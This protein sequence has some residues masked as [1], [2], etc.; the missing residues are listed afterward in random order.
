[1]QLPVSVLIQSVLTEIWFNN[2][3]ETISWLLAI[4]PILLNDNEIARWI[5]S[6]IARWIISEIGRF[7]REIKLNRNS[8]SNQPHATIP[9]PNGVLSLPI[10]YGNNVNITVHT[11]TNAHGTS[12]T[13]N[14]TSKPPPPY[15]LPRTAKAIPP[16]LPPNAPPATP[17]HPDSPPL[18][19]QK[20]TPGAVPHAPRTPA[21][22]GN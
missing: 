14:Y 21:G 17:S 10:P 6:E 7:T 2:S 5:I 19:R 16:Q 18:P 8:A 20:K 13:L 3:S 15:P 9:T 4:V 11:T 22:A 1:M 12:H